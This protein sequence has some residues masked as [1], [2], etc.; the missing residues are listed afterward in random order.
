M[1]LNSFCEE[2]MVDIVKQAPTTPRARRIHADVYGFFEG[3]CKDLLVLYPE[4]TRDQEHFTQLFARAL[5]A[6]Y[7]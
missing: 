2:D 5:S 3:V 6:K 7:E 4:C 1:I